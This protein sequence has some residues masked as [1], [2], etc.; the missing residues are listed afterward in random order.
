MVFFSQSVSERTNDTALY[1]NRNNSYKA[2]FLIRDKHCPR[3]LRTIAAPLI[4]QY[5]CRS[6]VQAYDIPQCLTTA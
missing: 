1:T 5:F 4:T 6:D 2:N 3:I